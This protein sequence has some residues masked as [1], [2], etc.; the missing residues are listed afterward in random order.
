MRWLLFFLL[1]CPVLR[2]AEPGLSLGAALKR[3]ELV[4]KVSAENWQALT[5][6]IANTGKTPVLLE[7]PAGLIASGVNDGARL[8][9]LRP[10]KQEIAPASHVD[11][12]I[13]AAALASGK[14]VAAQEFRLTEESE[15]RLTALLDYLARNDDVPRETAQLAVFAVLENFNFSQ[16]RHFLSGKAENPPEPTPAQVT[17]AVDALAIVRRVYPDKTFAL[18]EDTELKMRALRNPWSRAKAAQ[19]YG[20]DGPAAPLPPDIGTLLH[21]KPGDN[22]PVC[23]QRALLQP[24]EDGF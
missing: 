21:T 24:R 20:L 12:M 22:C 1:L 13:P 18:S 5:V 10:V 2:A 8:I 14:A 7:Q 9:T 19:L 6:S 11:L 3:P 23:R 16:W 17:A 15:P 4:C